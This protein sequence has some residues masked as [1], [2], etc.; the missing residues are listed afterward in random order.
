MSTRLQRR[1]LED[2]RCRKAERERRAKMRA[3]M[4]SIRRIAAQWGRDAER[5]AQYDAARAAR[6]W[7]QRLFSPYVL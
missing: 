6:P 2:G 7:W 4:D 5:W 3:E 1:L